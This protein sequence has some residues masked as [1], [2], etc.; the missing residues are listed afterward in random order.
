MAKLDAFYERWI[1]RRRDMIKHQRYP[2]GKRA[3]FAAIVVA[4]SQ[5]STGVMAQ[6]EE[7][8]VTAQ[9]RGQSLQDV[10]ISLNVVDGESLKKFSIGAFEDLDVYIPNL[11]IKNT[12]GNNAIYMRGIGSSPGNLAFEQSVSL[13]VDNIYAGR[14]RQFQAPFLD[15]QRVE[16]LRGPQGA[17]VG[18][19][20]AAGAINIVHAMPTE[21]F[22]GEVV[23]SYE[24]EREGTEVSGYLSGPVSENFRARLALRY[25]DRNG[26][27]TN[28]LRDRNE[29]DEEDFA[30]RATGVWDLS[31]STTVIGK[32]EFSQSDNFGSPVE[33]L[34]A[35]EFDY[36]SLDQIKETDGRLGEDFDNTDAVNGMVRI[37]W[38]VGEHTVSSITG[39]SEYD[40]GKDVDSD[41]SASGLPPIPG[42]V[43][44]LILSFFE[45][46]FEQFSQEVRLASPT[47]QTMEYIAGAY[48]HSQDLQIIRGTN[49]AFGPF[50]GAQ[51]RIFSQDDELWSV[52]GQLT[53]NFSEAI[54]AI[55]SVRHTWE[56]KS[57]DL[58]RFR[59]GVAP[60]L[61]VPNNFSIERSE[62]QTDPAATLQWDVT[63]DAMLYFS[64]AVGSK[65]GGFNGASNTAT[66]NGYEYEDEESESFEVGAKLR[67]LDGSATFNVAVF[68]DEYKNMQRSAFDGASFAFTT[69][70][71][72]VAQ[73]RGV[74]IDGAI[75][76]SKYL[77][78]T[79]AVAYLNA[80]YDDFPDSACIAL[81]ISAPCT[82]AGQDISGTP[83]PHAPDWSGNLAL[84]YEQPLN[85]GLMLS[86]DLMVVYQDSIYLD[87]RLD[88][89]MS[90]DG[91][92]KVDL[93]VGLSS[94]DGKRGVAVVGRNLT[95]ELTAQHGFE[96]PI[97]SAFGFRT[98]YTEP[99]RTVAIEGALRF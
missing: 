18:K 79:G 8:I 25:A 82:P 33:T 91:Y 77:T 87:D 81:P 52:Y 53:W 72:A 65:G 3:V 20:S 89:R 73:A 46:D 47:G 43:D 4:I 97:L 93:R 38:D 14:G 68:F 84:R 28:T 54:R 41:F 1:L 13:Y 90:Q 40:M 92:A 95:D 37:N 94:A 98:L 17:L 51:T 86:G 76:L 66:P 60:P 67:L 27:L 26:Y 11:Y 50:S 59:D 19:N 31:D 16:V 61:P 62:N 58:E 5:Y 22:E 29:P 23:A 48:F 36:K 55:V 45:E 30:I 83:L 15:I 96:T 56:D 70:N 10:P 88:P 75:T 9:K 57:A 80:E 35:A 64:Y 6:L 74:E 32:L 21:E 2:L 42:V 34:T 24:F 12:P 78:L 71:A 85:N 99:P 49:Y 7:I 69:R 39:Y 63:D 44:D